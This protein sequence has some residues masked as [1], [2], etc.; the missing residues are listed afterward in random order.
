MAQPAT[1]AGSVT[2]ELHS[3]VGPV[4]SLKPAA[5]TA[6]AT[7]SMVDL[8]GYESALVLVD[9]G[10]WTDGTHTPSLEDSD[11]DSTYAAVAAG[12]LVGSFT[13]IN[14]ATLDDVIYKVGY[15][16]KK[17]YLKAKVTVSGAT[18]GAILGM[19]VVRGHPRHM[20]VA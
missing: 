7:G 12:D 11:D 1:S 9:A 8:S 18:T 20:P 3:E 2:R 15:V 5:R 4:Q 19:L 6:T 17:R 16:G 10:T 13:V 14:G